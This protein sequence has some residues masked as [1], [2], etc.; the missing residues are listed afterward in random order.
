MKI[1]DKDGQELKFGDKVENV[2]KVDEDR[3]KKQIF[4][5]VEDG[6]VY[7]IYENFKSKSLHYETERYANGRKCLA[8]KKREEEN[9]K[10]DKYAHC[11]DLYCAVCASMPCTRQ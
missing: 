7:C 10:E 8:I 9:K 1:F 4:C 5:F 2:F 6:T 11:R 3:Y